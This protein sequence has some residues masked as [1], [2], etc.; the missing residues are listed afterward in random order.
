MVYY[1]ITLITNKPL[2][3]QCTLYINPQCG[4][5]SP[6]I[7]LLCLSIVVYIGVY[8]PL[9]PYRVNITNDIYSNLINL[10]FEHLFI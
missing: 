10:L 2:H 6:T 7:V 3:V 8:I 9:P 4:R 1:S 5:G